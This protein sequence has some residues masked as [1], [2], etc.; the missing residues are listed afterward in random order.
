MIAALSWRLLRREL[1]SGEL[2]LL[3]AALLIAVAAVTAVGFF[4]DRVRQGLQREAQQMMGGDLVI[5]ADHPLPDSYRDEARRRNLR[6]AET[7]VFP[8][9]VMAA[10]QAHLADG[11]S[12][13]L[14]VHG[15]R[16]GAPAQTLDAFCDGAG[17]DQN[18]FLAPAHQVG[19]FGG[20]AFQGGM[21]EPGTVV[22]DKTRSDFDHDAVGGMD[23]RL[24]WDDSSKTNG[25]GTRPSPFQEDLPRIIAG[26]W[27][28]REGPVVSFCRIPDR[29][30]REPAACVAIRRCGRPAAGAGRQPARAGPAAV[31]GPPWP[32]GS[33]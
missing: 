4:G 5:T 22:G 30:G 24:H 20:P 32:G 16:F 29:P 1:R 8:S 23:D 6:L 15:R 3:F 12:S 18:H 28:A 33:R 26:G 14:F 2:R 27:Q 7:L 17:T 10:G 19:D 9:M 13:L 31:S 25:G 21:V 11:G